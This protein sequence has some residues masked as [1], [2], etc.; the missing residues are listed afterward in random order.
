MYRLSSSVATK[1]TTSNS[2]I[3]STY[4]TVDRN[5]F[6]RFPIVE[7]MK[8]TKASNVISRI[9]KIFSIYGYIDRIRS[10]NGQQNKAIF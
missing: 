1:Q 4:R 7:L 3:R 8:S 9:D 5:N 6:S 10:D 2:H